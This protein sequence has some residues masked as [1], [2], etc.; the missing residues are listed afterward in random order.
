MNFISDLFFCE[1][2]KPMFFQE[3]EF[4]E[5]A[6]FDIRVRDVHSVQM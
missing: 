5:Q 2:R 1:I 6:M 3:F 4:P